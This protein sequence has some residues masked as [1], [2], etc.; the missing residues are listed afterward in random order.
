MQNPEHVTL[1]G[2]Q[3]KVQR[4]QDDSGTFSF[5][6]LIRG[7]P[8][9][10]DLMATVQAPHLVL[11]TDTGVRLTGCVRI[12][13]HRASGSGPAAIQ[14]LEFEF[15]P[16]SPSSAS[17]E[18]TVDQKLDAILAELRALRGEVRALSLRQ[19]PQP[20]G[21][22]TPPTAGTKILDFEIPVDQ[23]STD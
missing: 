17:L 23:E 11:E 6:T 22:I 4:W 13:R 12:L 14:R 18:L 2:R 19:S 3:I 21:K 15:T 8:L 16:D 1:N 9:G 10:N 5:T 20:P 7:E